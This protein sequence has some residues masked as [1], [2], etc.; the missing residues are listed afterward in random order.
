MHKDDY[1]HRLIMTIATTNPAQI[2][3]DVSI[4]QYG[5]ERE[6]NLLEAKNELVSMCVLCNLCDTRESPE[7]FVIL[8]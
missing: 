1:D 3:C 5:F 8:L 4:L 7:R 6:T 2:C